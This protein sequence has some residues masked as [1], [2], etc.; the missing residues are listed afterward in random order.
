MKANCGIYIV[1]DL[2]RQQVGVSELLNRWIVPLDRRVDMFSLRNG[3]R[4]S[5]P[6]DVWPIFSTN[7]EPAPVG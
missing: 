2:G 6:F 1:D 3:V 4:F 7:L 5:V